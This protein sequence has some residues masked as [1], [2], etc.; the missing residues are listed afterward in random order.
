MNETPEELDGGVFVNKE[1][2]KEI[3]DVLQESIQSIDDW[4]GYATDYFRRKHDLEGEL[5]RYNK[6]VEDIL[7]K[8][9]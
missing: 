9:E 7:R 2:L 3:V 4:A 1:Y 6:T 5:E 8:I